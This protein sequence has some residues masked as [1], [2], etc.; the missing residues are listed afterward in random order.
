VLF[1][2]SAVFEK[3]QHLFHILDLL[4]TRY[5]QNVYTF[6]WIFKNKYSAIEISKKVLTRV[7][8]LSSGALLFKFTIEKLIPISK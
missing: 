2:S 7:G 1:L 8:T 3:S 5:L 4:F 6:S